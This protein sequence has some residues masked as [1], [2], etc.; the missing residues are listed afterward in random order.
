M[1]VAL[2]KK[3]KGKIMVKPLFN[4]GLTDDAKL[5]REEVFVKEQGF[6]KEFDENDSK[7]W[8]LVLYLDGIPI[9]TG[10]ILEID[11]ETYRIGRVAVRKN[12][13][14]MKVGTYT[15]KFLCNKALSLGARKAV[16]A[17]QVD[18][19][20]FYR[21][22]GFR[23]YPDGEVFYEEGV[24]HTMMYKILTRKRTGYKPFY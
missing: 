20:A 17:A 21:S 16:L 7:A 15:V 8:H 3:K 18:K 19:M 12:F 1:I 22:L 5:I 11:P 24:P 2:G 6:A 4:F 13:R 14:H 23:P 10:R 9:S